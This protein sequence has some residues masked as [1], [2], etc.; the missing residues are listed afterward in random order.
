[1]SKEM[2]NITN[3]ISPFARAVHIGSCGARHEIRYVA[4]IRIFSWM[5][6]SSPVLRLELCHLFR[7]GNKNPEVIRIADTRAS[8][9]S[10]RAVNSL[11]FLFSL[12]SP[13]RG[14]F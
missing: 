11:F 7:R 2:Y 9:T 12:V 8:V 10:A 13:P 4:M 5:Q 6:Y 1:M 14:I 3:L